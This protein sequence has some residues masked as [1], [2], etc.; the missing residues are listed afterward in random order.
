MDLEGLVGLFPSFPTPPFRLRFYYT[1]DSIQL[2][3]IWQIPKLI[4]VL[5]LANLHP[6]L[7]T[8]R[9]VDRKKKNTYIRYKAL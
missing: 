1:I 5:V 9:F 8:P 3:A 7:H 2:L 6:S 4:I